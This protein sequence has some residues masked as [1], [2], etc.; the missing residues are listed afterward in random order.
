[1]NAFTY[2]SDGTRERFNPMTFQP[3]GCCLCGGRVETVGLFVPA[4]A[5]M[6]AVVLRL[7]RRPTRPNSTPGIAYGLCDSCAAHP[8]VLDYVERALAAAAA[9]VVLQ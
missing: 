2:R 1:M 8:D 9:G 5:E 6:L 7:R 4:T 3:G